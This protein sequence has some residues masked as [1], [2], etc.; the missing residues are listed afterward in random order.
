MTSSTPPLAVIVGVGPGLGSTGQ[1]PRH[2]TRSAE[3][4]AILGR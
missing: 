2:P 3:S 4:L 1:S